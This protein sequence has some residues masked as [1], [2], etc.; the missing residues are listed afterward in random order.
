MCKLFLQYDKART[1]APDTL[2]EESNISS[3]A[4]PRLKANPS[5]TLVLYR[6]LYIS[7]T[8]SKKDY[9]DY[10]IEGKTPYG[11]YPIPKGRNN[12]IEDQI[13]S[14]LN[15]IEMNKGCCFGLFYV[16]YFSMIDMLGVV[17]DFF[18]S[19]R[20]YIYS[21]DYD[22]IWKANNQALM[23]LTDSG[24]LWEFLE[25]SNTLPKLKTLYASNRLN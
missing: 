17:C 13:A 20:M 19:K 21:K 24:A 15:D 1:S 8:K 4:I 23:W 5:L 3:L 12:I 18:V 2:F 9:H 10:L 22:G 6:T 25:F 11:F 7:E 16:K 14:D